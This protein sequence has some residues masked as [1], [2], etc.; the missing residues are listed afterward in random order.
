MNLKTNKYRGTIAKCFEELQNY[1]T[2]EQAL[3]VLIVLLSVEWIKN[4]KV[5]CGE[6]IIEFRILNEH[7]MT[8]SNFVGILKEEIALFEENNPLF[9]KILTSLIENVI[10]YPDINISKMFFS[11]YEIIRNSQFDS[12]E[13]KEMILIILSSEFEFNRFNDTPDS[14]IKLIMGL[15]D[16]NSTKEMAVFCCGYS[17]IALGIIESLKTIEGQNQV[18]YYGEEIVL[19]ISL[20]SR[21]LMIIFEIEG[22]TI[23]NKDVLSFDEKR[24][25]ANK[26]DLVITD[27]PL[28]A[29]PKSD[30]FD[31]PRLHYGI[32]TKNSAEWYFGQ[33]VIF[34]MNDKGKGILLTTKGALVRSNETELRMR[35]LEEDLLECVITLPNNLYEKSTLGTEMIILNKNKSEARKDKV[36]FINASEHG[37]RLN[38]LQHAITE[39]GISEIA[40]S[41]RDGIERAHFSKLVELDKIREFKY[42][43]NPAEYLDFDTLKDSLSETVL[44]K[45]IAQVIRGMNVKKETISEDFDES[46]YGCLNIKDIDN[47]KINYDNVSKFQYVENDWIKKYEIK[48]NDIIVTAK[49][50]SFKF[51]IVE[52]DFRPSLISSNLTIIRVDSEKYNPYVLLEFFQSEIG[53]RMIDSL[54]TGST[55]KVLNNSQLERFEIPIFDIEN[56]NLIGSKIKK[57]RTEHED[58]LK[59]ANRKFEESKSEYTQLLK[60]FIQSKNN[61]TL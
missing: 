41:Y 61:K 23:E 18:N 22:T 50:W 27:T 26:Y 12:S 37:L 25:N 5:I 16:F 33:N 13:I 55:V 36:L 14:V 29:N 30:M 8:A 48:P 9:K 34:H 53:S 57:A 1:F 38:R 42:K 3:E 58:S 45:D 59:A 46:L 21:L 60:T 20:I 4:R 39:D 43:L 2:P 52:D 35:I 19:S 11:V 40:N 6:E 17:K 24:K 56:M 15:V 10:N 44:L 49:G 54:Q 28:I 32:P 31:D 7:D 51:A 47:G